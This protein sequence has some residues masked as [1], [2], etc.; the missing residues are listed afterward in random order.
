M[1]KR[2]PQLVPVL[3]EGA[4]MPYELRNVIYLKTN[5]ETFENTLIKIIANLNVCEMK[6]N[7]QRVT[8]RRKRS[9]TS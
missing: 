9:F 7:K 6:R 4:E 3:F 5:G 8:E 2:T 1:A